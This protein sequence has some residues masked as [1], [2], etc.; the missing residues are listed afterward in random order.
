[1]DAAANTN[2]TSSTTSITNPFRNL[3]N[4]TAAASSPFNTASTITRA[5]SLM[6][7]PQF[8][9]VWLQ[10]YN[11]TNRYN[12]LQLQLTKRLSNS[13]SLNASYTYSRLRERLAYL[14]PSDTVLEDR[15]GLDDRPESFHVRG[16]L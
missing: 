4:G 9:N 8:T 15:I 3:L 12:A 6:Q 13:V 10:E 1:L 14:N 11:G 5:Q 2:L 16:D 7:F